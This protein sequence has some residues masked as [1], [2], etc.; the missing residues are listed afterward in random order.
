VKNVRYTTGEIAFS[1]EGASVREAAVL[2]VPPGTALF[3]TDRATWLEGQAI[4]VVRLAHAPGYRL[5]A[6][7]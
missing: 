5:Q 3:I 2:G 6:G 1:A 4:T 7:L